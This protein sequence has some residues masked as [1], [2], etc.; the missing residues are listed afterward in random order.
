MKKNIMFFILGLIVSGFSVYALNID[1]RNTY[2]DN[3]ISGSS[4]TNMQDAIDDLYDKANNGPNLIKCGDYTGTAATMTVNV[5][6]YYDGDLS[7]LTADNF[8]LEARFYTTNFST[9]AATGGSN[10]Q[11][12]TK[13]YNKSTGVLTINGLAASKSVTTAWSVSMRCDV[14]V[15]LNPTPFR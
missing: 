14:T 7:A 1:A 10:G 2:Y 9:Q 13:S 11:S 12:I 3:T 4:A 6:N 15:W 8:I 5:G